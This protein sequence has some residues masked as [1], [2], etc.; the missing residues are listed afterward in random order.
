MAG[1]LHAALD[2]LPP[3]SVALE[4]GFWARL[5]DLN[6]TD[7]IDHCATWAERMGWIANF[8]AAAAGS[9]FDRAGI[10]FV[11]SDVYKLLEA[12]A[13]EVARTGDEQLEQRYADIADRVVAAQEADGYL[14]T[15]FGRPGQRPRYSD[16]EWGHELY[17]FGHLFQAA[18]ARLRSGREDRLTAA[19]LRLADHLHATFGPGGRAAVCGHPE[20]ELGLVDLYRA[21]GRD[22]D[23]ELAR[24]FVDRRGRGLLGPIE[25]GPAYFQ[26]DVPVR[27]AEV[28]RGHAVRALYLAA[29]AVDVAVETGDEALLHAVEAQWKRTMARRTYLTGGMGSRHQDES[30]GEDYE[31]PPDRAYAETCAA[32][33]SVMLARRLLLA[34]G[35]P[36]YADTIER[37]LLNAVLC[38]PREDGRA[39]FYANTL[40]Q[41]TAGALA[42]ESVASSRAHGL[43]RSPWFDVSCCPTN[44]ARTVANVGELFATGDESGLQLHLYG[45]FS[46]GTTLAN[47]DRLEVRVRSGYPNAE[48]VEVELLPPLPAASRIDLRVPPWTD[49]RAT[50]DLG[51]GAE[52]VPG[53]QIRVAGPLPAGTHVVARFP[54]RPRFVAADDR[55]DAVRGQVAVEKGPFVLAVED[56]DL[57]SGAHV[58]DLEIDTSTPPLATP[59]GADVRVL[60]RRRPDSPW[61]YRDLTGAELRDESHEAVVGYRPYYRWGNRGPT[62]MRVWTPRH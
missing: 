7:I 22:Q 44:V 3:G 34:T 21:T 37:T 41:R 24:L 30:F 14:H 49:G 58:A 2:A 19:A 40:H 13:H 15:A 39:F 29:A 35:D 4:G 1:R 50:V 59:D 31:L 45:D 8:D 52:P 60:I 16:L 47:G 12:M 46:A 23:L 32:I 11:D 38:S 53:R 17:C 6:H 25:F 62:T 33:A 42:D 9:A 28:L 57:P 36:R 10:E 18:A 61:P 51:T 54:M 5:Q 56:V 20:V 55:I 43:L 27:E 48:R 26:D